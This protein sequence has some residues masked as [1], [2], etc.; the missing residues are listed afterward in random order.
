MNSNFI[1][2]FVNKNDKQNN[3]ILYNQQTMDTR[4]NNFDN[5]RKSQFKVDRLL[6]AENEL[7]YDMINTSNPGHF[8]SESMYE[9]SKDISNYFKPSEPFDNT[10]YLTDLIVDDR[11]RKNHNEWVTEVTPWAGTA[12]IVGA[13]EFSAGDYLNFQGLRRPRGVQQIDPWQIT[14]VDEEQLADNRPFVI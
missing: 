4:N 3:N 10:A 5:A 14:E 11:I 13:A 9:C 7:Y 2:G 8:N 6:Q 12:S 1:D